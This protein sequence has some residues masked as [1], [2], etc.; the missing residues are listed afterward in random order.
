MNNLRLLKFTVLT[1]LLGI[2]S[3]GGLLA[4]NAP[5]SGESFN[6]DLGNLDPG[7][8]V[9]IT[10]DVTVDVTIP[11]NVTQVCNQ[12]LVT[13]NNFAD[14]LTDD[15]DVGGANDPTCTPIVQPPQELDFGD[16]PD[17]GAGT[18]PDQVHRHR[19]TTMESRL[20]ST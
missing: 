6:L 19:P 1:L 8:T 18:G 16:A 3:A 11:P 12:G 20:E 15:P 7:Q 9:V 2:V 5:M 10:F 4:Q 17:V 13:G 14:V